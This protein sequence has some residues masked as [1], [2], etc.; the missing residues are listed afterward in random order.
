M[1]S[2]RT[3]VWAVFGSVKMVVPE[4]RLVSLCEVAPIVSEQN[5]CGVLPLSWHMSQEIRVG[6]R[7]SFLQ[8]NLGL[9]AHS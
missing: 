3:Q 4:Q 1:Q 8:G 6:F 7:K 2:F 5:L 9:P